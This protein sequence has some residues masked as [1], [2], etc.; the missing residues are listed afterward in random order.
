MK[1]SELKHSNVKTSIATK[2]D[3]SL[4][5]SILVTA[6]DIMAIIATKITVIAF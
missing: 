3:K 1:Y 2:A 5:P 4:K 6:K